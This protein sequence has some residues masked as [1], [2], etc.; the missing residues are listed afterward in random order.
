M[1]GSSSVVRIPNVV[2]RLREV[3]ESKV[4]FLWE[5]NLSKHFEIFFFWGGNLSEDFESYSL[6]KGTCARILKALFLEMN[7]L[8][9]FESFS[10]GKGI[11][12]MT[13]IAYFVGK[14]FVSKN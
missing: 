13:S 14:E 9:D 2:G 4:Y 8:E 1:S 11:C 7:S 12:P 6:G 3:Q 10:I 5:G